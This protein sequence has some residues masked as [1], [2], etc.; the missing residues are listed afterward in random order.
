[1]LDPL[2]PCFVE[3]SASIGSDRSTFLME[4]HFPFF[5]SNYYS[6]CFHPSL[7]Y[8][9]WSRAVFSDYSRDKAQLATHN[10]Q[11][12]CDKKLSKNLKL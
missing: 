7:S 4:F 11:H 8:L 10:S 6:E 3:A 2:E 12:G 5:P 9:R 1:M